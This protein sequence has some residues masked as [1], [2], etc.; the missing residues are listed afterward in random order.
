MRAAVPNVPARSSPDFS[1]FA[2]HPRPGQGQE[3]FAL[4]HSHIRTSVWEKGDKCISRKSFVCAFLLLLWLSLPLP[5]PRAAWV[6]V[7][8]LLIAKLLQIVLA[9][10]ARVYISEHTASFHTAP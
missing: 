10:L 6:V 4:P 5:L 9:K 2:R 8:D 7:V 1:G 3:K